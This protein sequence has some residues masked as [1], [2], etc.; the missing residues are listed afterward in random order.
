MLRHAQRDVDKVEDELQRVQDAYRQL[1][2]QIRRERADSDTRLTVQRQ[3]EH[4]VMD[5]KSQLEALRREKKAKNVDSVSFWRDRGHYSQELDFLKNAA[6]EEGIVLDQLRSAND[7]LERCQKAYTEQASQLERQRKELADMLAREERLMQR[8]ELQNEEA[9]AQLERMR[10][11]TGDSKG[12]TTEEVDLMKHRLRSNSS[13][14][15]ASGGAA[16]A[17]GLASAPDAD[18]RSVRSVRS[19]RSVAESSRLP[20]SE[21]RLSERQPPVMRPS[22]AHSWASSLIGGTFGL[23][24]G[25]GSAAEDP[26][27]REGV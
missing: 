2:Q 15:I 13:M 20:P 18:N 4:Q 16:T 25:V 1:Q 12:I 7:Y 19:G 14:S 3:L 27:S 10:R 11:E 8:D 24:S 17:M 26:R 22:D 5:A 23:P 21:A 9:R 6:E